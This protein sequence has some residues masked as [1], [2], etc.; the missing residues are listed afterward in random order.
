MR[1]G[2]YVWLVGLGGGGTLVPTRVPTYSQPS[3]YDGTWLETELA[4]NWGA[5]IL[6]AKPRDTR[7]YGFCVETMGVLT[8]H[9]G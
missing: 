4:E 7:A 2:V 6:T 9:S 1:S 5:C 3:I 8:G